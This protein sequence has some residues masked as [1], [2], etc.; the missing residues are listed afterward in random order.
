MSLRPDQP[1]PEIVTDPDLIR[2]AERLMAEER[3]SCPACLAGDLPPHFR[4]H[5]RNGVLAQTPCG[6]NSRIFDPATGTFT[7]Y[8]HCTC[9][10]CF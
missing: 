4:S 7:G 8:P 2:K 10:Y 6:G 9:D 5:V 1:I 3:A